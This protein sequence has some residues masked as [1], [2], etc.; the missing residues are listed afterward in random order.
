LTIADGDPAVIWA[1]RDATHEFEGSVEDIETG[2]TAT[3]A[4]DLTLEAGHVYLLEP[5]AI[6]AGAGA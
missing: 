6:A 1:I 2:E 5:A 4:G 3:V